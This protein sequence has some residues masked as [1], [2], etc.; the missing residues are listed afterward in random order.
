MPCGRDILATEPQP[1]TPASFTIP[2]G[3]GG[4]P[5][6]VRIEG[7]P[8]EGIF[9]AF[10]RCVVR[11]GT[12]RFVFDPLPEEPEVSFRTTLPAGP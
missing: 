7:V 10:R 2:Y 8:S 1:D 6:N 12:E 3:L 9:L 5:Q 4:R 11:H